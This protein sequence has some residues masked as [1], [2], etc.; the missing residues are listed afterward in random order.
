[1]TEDPA[2]MAAGLAKATGGAP[3]LCAATAAN[4]EAMA[5]LAKDAKAPLAVRARLRRRPGRADREAGGCRGRGSGARPGR[6]RLRR[7]AGRR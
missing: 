3:L 7:L 4:W 2:L 1:M 5:K 6:A